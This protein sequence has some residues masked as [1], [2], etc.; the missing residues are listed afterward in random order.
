M[1]FKKCE[2]IFG[3]Q[4]ASIKDITDDLISKW[5]N[6]RGI[7]LTITA[8]SSRWPRSLKDVDIKVKVPRQLPPE[9][10]FV[11]QQFRRNWNED[12]WLVEL[13]QRYVSLY[14]IKRMRVKDGS[15]L[16]AVR[17]D[18]KTTEEVRTHIKSG[19]INVGSMIHPVKPYHLPIP[20]H[21]CL[22][23][24][25]HDR[26]TKSCSRPR[27][28]PRCAEEHS[29]AHGCPNHEG[30]VNCGGNHISG[31]SACPVVQEKRHSL[32]KQSKRQTSELLVRA[33]QQQHLYHFQGSDYPALLNDNQSYSSTEISHQTAESSQKSYTQVTL[34][35]RERGSPK[36]IE[37]S[38]FVFFLEQ[39]G[40]SVG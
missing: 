10:S 2:T 15:T 5:K 20:I 4:P 14:K 33:K 24:L 18:F 29:L 34:N 11:I 16:N 40:T 25:R 19:K 21:K 13:Q 6:Q 38:Y 30:C 17:A 26:T 1:T 35:Q 23:C 8:H 36:N 7:D 39:N 31:H 3:D 37:Y 12:E 32:A 9:Y 28:C 27:L 22:K